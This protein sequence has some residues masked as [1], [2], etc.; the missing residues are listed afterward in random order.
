MKGS[1]RKDRALHGKSEE[2]KGLQYF[3]P[4]T[5]MRIFFQAAAQH[6]T[7]R[8]GEVLQ[9]NRKADLNLP[10]GTERTGSQAVLAP[11]AAPTH[12]DLYI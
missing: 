10:L 1:L 8:T 7:P 6:A 4:D 2:K 3:N 11:P 9:V 12:E 5:P